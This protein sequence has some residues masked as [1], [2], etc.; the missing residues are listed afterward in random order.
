[1]RVDPLLFDP[2]DANQVTAAYPGFGFA[3]ANT[4]AQRVASYVPHYP[5]RSVYDPSGEVLFF[6]ADGT[7][8]AATMFGGNRTLDREAALMFGGLRTQD[9]TVTTDALFGLVTGFHV[10]TTDHV[11]SSC[12]DAYIA[13]LAQGSSVSDALR[14][15][16]AM[17]IPG[18]TLAPSWISSRVRFDNLIQLHDENEAAA[19]AALH[20][21]GF[22]AGMQQGEHD[23]YWARAGLAG[24]SPPWP[25]AFDPIL[26][27]QA[28]AL[29]LGPPGSP[30]AGF[31]Q[32]S[33][34]SL[35]A[36]LIAKLT[37]GLPALTTKPAFFGPTTTK[38]ASETPSTAPRTI[39]DA[40]V[41]LGIGV[42]GGAILGALVGASA[43]HTGVGVGVAGG[44][45]VGVGGWYAVRKKF[46][47]EHFTNTRP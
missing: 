45:L 3:E 11:G 19:A 23:E 38:Q 35:N 13:A 17:G 47:E 22:T 28:A 36:G 32:F 39:D 14:Q 43:G 33:P 30:P 20:D 31:V 40:I 1:M 18:A 21:P 37:P 27:D 16:R 41:Q 8:G 25:P 2:G 44:A 12:A 15:V 46:Y 6:V 9:L 24:P 10:G 4:V 5:A 42:A 26:F 34:A 7:T 29:N